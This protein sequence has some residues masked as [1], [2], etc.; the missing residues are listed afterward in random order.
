MSSR[1]RH[2]PI[3][4]KSAENLARM[5]EEAVRCP[6]CDMHVMPVDLLAHVAERCPGLREP[7][8]RST[9]VSRREAVAMGLP[10]G[11]LSQWA[12]HG[13]VRVRG[14]RQDRRYLLRDLVL[15]IAQRRDLVLR[16]VKGRR[17]SAA[18]PQPRSE[19]R[20]QLEFAFVRRR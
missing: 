15:R 12:R 4:Q 8:P 10:E 11:M 5:R 1:Y 17:E 18:R 16:I 9:W 13:E 14:E 3:A 19:T 6:S 7:S 20:M 2:L